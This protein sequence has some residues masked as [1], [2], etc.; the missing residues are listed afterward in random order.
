MSR[1][2]YAKGTQVSSDRTVGQIKG[3]VE[4]F[5]AD[6]FAFASHNK[7]GMVSFRY[8]GRVV[9]F[10]LPL[11]DR[12]SEQFTLTERGKERSPTA[13]MKSWEEA[14]RMK[15]RSLFLLIKSLLIA[16]EDG[17][18]D[19]DRA[20]FHDIVT[21]DGTT[22]GEQLMRKVQHMIENGKPAPLQLVYAEAK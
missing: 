6:T 12:T 14:C 15:W 18:L 17:L 21:P 10:E 5:G 9:R 13:A 22:V 2:G 4:R 19:F 20:F 8:R 7:G 3:I 1:Y 11:P 16:I